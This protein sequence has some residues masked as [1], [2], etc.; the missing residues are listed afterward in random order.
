MYKDIPEYEDKYAFNISDKAI[1]IA[2]SARKY[3]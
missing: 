3:P 1:D 2:L